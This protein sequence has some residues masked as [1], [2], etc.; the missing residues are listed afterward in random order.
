[1][2]YTIFAVLIFAIF[3]LSGCSSSDKGLHFEKWESDTIGYDFKLT[4]S[5][6]KPEY[7]FGEDIKITFVLQNIG[8]ESDTIAR[9]F[10]VSDYLTKKMT[11]INESGDTL[12]HFGIDLSFPEIHYL[13]LNPGEQITATG[14]LNHSFSTRF[15][16]FGGRYFDSG[17]YYIDC[18][19]NFLSPSQ[20]SKKYINSNRIDFSVKKATDEDLNIF[21]QLKKFE[22]NIPPGPYKQ[23][24]MQGFIDSARFYIRKYPQSVF[25]QPVFEVFAQ[26]RE[27]FHYK[28]D[29][30]LLDDIEL[31][32]EN[33]P[34]SEYNRHYIY[35]CIDLFIKK[36]GGKEKAKEYLFYLKEKFKNEKLNGIIDEVSAKDESLNK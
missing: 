11:C 13:I 5:T 19:Y 34:G 21:N 25:V 6:D 26:N 4:I 8:T 10:F 14:I 12:K 3:G 22:N 29:E 28:Y 20:F 32:I 31:L 24:A 27:W 23:E 1:M 9:T 7:E 18:G 16:F 36:L 17:K 35:N 2:K 15:L 33:N 30:T